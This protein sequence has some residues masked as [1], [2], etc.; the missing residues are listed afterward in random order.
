[1]SILDP[2]NQPTQ[3]PA[4]ITALMLK[5]HV[6]QTYQ[7]IVAAFT[8]GSRAFWANTAGIPAADIAEALGTDGQ[9]VFTLHAKLGEFIASVRPAAVADGLSVVGEFSYSE[10][11]RVI[12]AAPEPPPEIPLPEPELPPELP[13]EEEPA[14]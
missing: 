14:V 2:V 10:D 9:E 7:Y 1:M 13:P 5:E 11:G 8:E 3:T 4:E 6:R 12:V